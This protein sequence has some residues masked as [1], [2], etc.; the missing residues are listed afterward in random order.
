MA[1]SRAPRAQQPEKGSLSRRSAWSPDVSRPTSVNGF[2]LSSE[3]PAIDGNAQSLE[4]IRWR[5]TLA[6]DSELSYAWESERGPPAFMAGLMN[7]K[8]AR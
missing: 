6:R 3:T 2:S 7:R 1:R 5:A 4:H 8:L